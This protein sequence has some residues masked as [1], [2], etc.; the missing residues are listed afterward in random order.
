MILELK[1]TQED[2]Q[3]VKSDIMAHKVT[4]LDENWIQDGVKISDALSE[5]LNIKGRE[6]YSDFS[7]IIEKS[8][9]KFNSYRSKGNS[10]SHNLIE[11]YHDQFFSV[12]DIFQKEKIDV[13]WQNSNYWWAQYNKESD[14]SEI[15]QRESSHKNYLKV[16]KKLKLNTMT[17]IC[18]ALKTKKIPIKYIENKL[19][20]D[21]YFSPYEYLT[22]FKSYMKDLG[23]VAQDKLYDMVDKKRSA[24]AVSIF[25]SES[26]QIAK[27]VEKIRKGEK[28]RL[29]LEKNV[30]YEEMNELYFLSLKK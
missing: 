12:V 30:T 15:Y 5:I 27:Y 11:F 29:F 3:N 21:S 9:D 19:M 22:I 20:N 25:R 24:M 26:T 4:S 13:K 2:Q 1:L 8:R 28:S 18:N 16:C 10:Q 7:E 23:F 6:I 14:N 17:Q